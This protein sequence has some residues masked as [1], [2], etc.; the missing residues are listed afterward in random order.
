MEEIDHEVAAK[1]DD[2]LPLETYHAAFADGALLRQAGDA[3]VL[4][5]KLL[6]IDR[7]LRDDFDNEALFDELDEYVALDLN[8]VTITI[9]DNQLDVQVHEIQHHLTTHLSQLR[10]LFEQVSHRSLF[11]S[12][13]KATVHTDYALQLRQM[14]LE[15]IMSLHL[16][17]LY[18][19]RINQS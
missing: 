2:S 5:R 17:I 18:G 1:M 19:A 4:L 9:F 12:H 7:L 13:K 11:H 10:Q 3:S 14:I 8:M 15:E 16:A 6:N